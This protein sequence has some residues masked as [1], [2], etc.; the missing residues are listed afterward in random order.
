MINKIKRKRNKMKQG[1]KQRHLD[2]YMGIWCHEGRQKSTEK[3][4]I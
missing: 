4:Y 1:F 3:S 2:G